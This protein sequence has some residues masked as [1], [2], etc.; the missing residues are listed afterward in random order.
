MLSVIDYSYHQRHYI[1][2][3]FNIW[4]SRGEKKS[5]LPAILFWKR[6]KMKGEK[7][8]LR[9]QEI[10]PFYFFSS[11]KFPHAVSGINL[12]TQA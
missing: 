10:L 9:S 7:N 2:L 5:V 4:I 8:K 11:L 1:S 6:I 3:W 12:L